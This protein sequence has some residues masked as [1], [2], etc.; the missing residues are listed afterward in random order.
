MADALTACPALRSASQS[1]SSAV[2]LARLARMVAVAAPMLRR[3]CA[4][5][6]AWRAATGNGCTVRRWPTPFGAVGKP[7]NVV[8]PAPAARPGSS[9]C[10]L[11][12]RGQDLCQV[13]GAHAGPQPR[14]APADVHQ[15]GAVAGRADLGT[16]VQ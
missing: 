13:D 11:P 7:R 3:S 9:S 14:Q 16:G 2:T 15:A 10:L 5:P 12:L 8:M 1:G 4:S 6:S